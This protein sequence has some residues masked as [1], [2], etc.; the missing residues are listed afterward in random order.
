MDANTTPIQSIGIMTAVQKPE[1]V[2]YAGTIARKLAQ[3]DISVRVNHE[4]HGR[5]ESDCEC[6]DD[7]ALAQTDIIIVL[8]GDGTLLNIARTAAP[9]DTPL[10]GLDVG[11]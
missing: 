3:M 11:S 8:G 10:L 2:E 1:A 9:Y 7:E 6:C 4:M 5:V